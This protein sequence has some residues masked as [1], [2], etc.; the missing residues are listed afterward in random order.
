[1][2][3]VIKLQQ[4][5]DDDDCYTPENQNDN[6]YYTPANIKIYTSVQLELLFFHFGTENQEEQ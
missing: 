2:R 1:M 6:D 3:I 5:D 4:D